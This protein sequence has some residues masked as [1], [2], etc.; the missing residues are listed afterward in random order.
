[1]GAP[2]ARVVR[3]HGPHRH[4]VEVDRVAGAHLEDL[5]G[6]HRPEQRGPTGRHDQSPHRTEA[7]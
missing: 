1:M 4:P 3:R 7:A 5:I 6:D 2:A